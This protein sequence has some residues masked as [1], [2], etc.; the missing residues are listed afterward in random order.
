MDDAPMVAVS[1][2]APC[3]FWNV[4]RFEEVRGVYLGATEEEGKGSAGSQASGGTQPQWP[5]STPPPLLVGGR[6]VLQ[7]DSGQEERKAHSGGGLRLRLVFVAAES[8]W[9]L[10]R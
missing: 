9:Y 5:V 2:N 1:C 6:R 8:R 4:S 3:A 10:T 7:R